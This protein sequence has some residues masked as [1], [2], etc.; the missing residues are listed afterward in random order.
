MKRRGFLTKL[1]A[2]LLSPLAIVGTGA[3]SQTNQAGQLAYDP[4]TKR[5]KPLV[6]GRVFRNVREWG[7]PTVYVHCV[8]V[9]CACLPTGRD[10]SEAYGC[11]FEGSGGVSVYFQT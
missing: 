11:R 3:T 8:F 9:D 6:H 1:V 7:E 4:I 2:L 10:H 5:T